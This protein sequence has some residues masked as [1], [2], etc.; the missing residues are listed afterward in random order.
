[1]RFGKE[2]PPEPVSVD[3]KAK[4]R[5][6]NVGNGT[7][8]L[9][10]NAVKFQVEKGRIRKHREIAKEIPITD[11]DSTERVGNEL[12]V[13]WKGV[14]ER[15]VI[16]NADLAEKIHAKLSETLSVQGKPL[17]SK[18]ETAKQEPD[19]FAQVLS[20]A[21]KITDSL[22]DVLRGLHGR[23]D[24]NRVESH[25]KCSKENVKSLA[26]QK[27]AVNLD[28]SKLSS[29]AKERLP[30]EISKEACDLLRV[31]L[32]YFNGLTSQGKSSAQLHPNHEDGKKLILAYY[33]LN[34]VILGT[35]VEDDVRKERD[36]LMIM[37]NALSN[38][39]AFKI[40]VGAVRDAISK[41][42]I[43]Q[44]RESAIEESRALFKQQLKE[45]LAT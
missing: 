10:G 15:F 27:G 39:T 38:E 32:E 16:E 9:V 13:T 17:E 28:I 24:W 2:Q 35:V 12:S 43:G 45:L 41:L 33:T 23:V 34:D 7:L 20:N 11:I 3:I 21:L 36:E 19:E 29:A 14:T 6:R 26:D 31:L 44:E 40:N 25:L 5:L 4:A 1:V 30:E 18:E 22:F 42:S 37:L 8:D